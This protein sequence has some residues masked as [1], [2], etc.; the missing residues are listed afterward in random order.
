METKLNPDLF[1]IINI[2]KEELNDL[3]WLG[4]GLAS[5][6]ASHLRLGVFIG[7][8]GSVA[9]P[10]FHK[11]QLFQAPEVISCVLCWVEA[12]VSS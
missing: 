8:N 5:F 11:V 2:R 9:S 3:T 10:P 6:F 12:N 7:R 1:L 4:L